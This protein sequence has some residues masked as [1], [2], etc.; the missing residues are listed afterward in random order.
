MWR[1][2]AKSKQVGG[3]LE[4]LLVTKIERLTCCC[5][6]NEFEIWFVD[7]S[8]KCKGRKIEDFIGLKVDV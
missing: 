3:T 4:H 8:H 2:E 6:H 5:C 7:L 1:F